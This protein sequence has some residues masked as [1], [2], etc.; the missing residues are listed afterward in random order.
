MLAP[1]MQIKSGKRET[2][3][4]SERFKLSNTVPLV[5]GGIEGFPRIPLQE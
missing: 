2:V 1:P 5:E 4:S 3:N